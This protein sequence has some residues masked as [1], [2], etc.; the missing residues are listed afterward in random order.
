VTT[1]AQTSLRTGGARWS[2]AAWAAAG[3]GVLYLIGVGTLAG[4]RLD[5]AAMRWA[6]A[7]VSDD[8]WARVLLT[9]VSAGSVLTVGASVAAVTAI[10]RGPRTA[11][12]GALSGAAVLLGAEVLKLALTRPG[13][14]VD[15][16]A[17]SFPSGHVAAV[18]GL[19]VGLLLA[20]PAGPWRW[21][22]MVGVAPVLALTGLATVVL[23][24]H[25]P[26]D[27]LGS[28]LL[29]VVVGVAAARWDQTGRPRRR[30][31]RSVDSRSVW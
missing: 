8:S 20:V 2:A 26:S 17:N 18:T 23:Q 15:A 27:A 9:W 13:F 3:F 25:R 30:Q 29:G 14:S 16:V 31:E 6:A 19:A 1:F 7:A 10:T 28:V 4:Q 12:L 5:D 11:L 21:A 24:W 22:A